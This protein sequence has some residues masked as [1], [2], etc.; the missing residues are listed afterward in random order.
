MP[1]APAPRRRITANRAASPTATTV[2]DHVR[3]A[4]ASLL[5]LGYNAW[6]K[7]GAFRHAVGAILAGVRRVAG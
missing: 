5:H 3:T 6:S 1:I 2:E 4:T 7:N